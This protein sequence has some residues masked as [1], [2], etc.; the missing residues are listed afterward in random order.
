MHQKKALA[1]L[2]LMIFLT[3]ALLAGCQQ[4]N[5]ENAVLPDR[6]ASK[7]T[8]A[9]QYGLGYA[10]LQI[11][12]EKKLVEKY[13]PG[14]EVEWKQMGTGPEIRE[15]MV[16]GQVDV[17]FMGISPFL[18][19]W[20]KGVKWK[21]AT[22]SCSQPLALMTYKENI[23]SLK[24]FG[25]ED[26]IATPAVASIQHIL[27]SMAAK[28]E[29]G[30]ARALDNNMISL[31][32]PDAATAL[33][34]KK[35]IAAHFASPPYLFEELADPGLKKVLTG[36]EAFGGEYTFIFGVATEKFHDGNPAAYA[37]FIAA[38]NEAVAFINSQPEEAASILAPKYNLSPEKVYEYITWEGTNY[39]STPYGIMAFARFMKEAGYIE[40][41]PASISDIAFANVQ[42]AIGKRYGEMSAIEK[43]QWGKGE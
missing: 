34:A 8:I 20:D 10:P 42:A 7:I 36:E 22:A 9:T 2:T 19:G 11:M 35:D 16:A 31:T 17:G 40:K 43:L 29:L 27:L 24:D 33:K 6:T 30:D 28:R 12:E 38:F 13:L 4:K 18:I 1:V 26:K 21:I 37:A 5:P 39:C 41:M 15:A 3:V 25:V 23:R 32:H 14:V